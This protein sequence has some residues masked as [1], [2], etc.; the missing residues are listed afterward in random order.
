MRAHRP[1]LH[2]EAQRLIATVGIRNDVEVLQSVLRLRPRPDT[3][4]YSW[5][6]VC[7]VV[8]LSYL[9]GL[10]VGAHFITLPSPK[11]G[12]VER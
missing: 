4:R 6:Y 9:L 11:A 2:R 12:S 8:E 3:R 7:S 10:R 5:R 1:S